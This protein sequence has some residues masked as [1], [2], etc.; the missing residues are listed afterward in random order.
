MLK[1]QIEN[2][3]DSWAIRWYASAFINNKY[4]LYPNI[5]II[6]NIGF[7]NSGIHSSGVD[8]SNNKAWNNKNPVIINK[9]TDIENNKL[10]LKRWSNYFH[11]NIFIRSIK[12][13]FYK[14]NRYDPF[15]SFKKQFIK[16]YISSNN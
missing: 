16:Y 2:K 3:I 15:I 7:D 9:I 14:R 6:Y 5:S 10:A 13:I 12:N 11:R 8:N 4:T 1:R